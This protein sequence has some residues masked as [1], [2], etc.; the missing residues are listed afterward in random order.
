[1]SNTD[2]RQLVASYIGSWEGHTQAEGQY[3]INLRDAME[4]VTIDE[5]NIE[6]NILTRQHLWNT[7][8]LD[9]FYNEFYNR[10]FSETTFSI[11]IENLSVSAIV[12]FEESY[13]MFDSEK[14]LTNNDFPPEV[15]EKIIRVLLHNDIN[16]VIHMNKI[17]GLENT[18]DRV[19]FI[20]SNPQGEII[21]IKTTVRRAP[22]WDLYHQIYESLRNQ[23]PVI[24]DPMQ[25][26]LINQLIDIDMAR[27]IAEEVE[28]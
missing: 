26:K 6:Y 19:Y 11:S 9:L 15:Q 20:D 1:M 18:D 17:I 23:N 4:N 25:D 28:V 22:D 12:G 16:A 14:T 3:Y 24:L 8:L 10:I 27:K 2:F 13:P 21:R 5:L 7:P